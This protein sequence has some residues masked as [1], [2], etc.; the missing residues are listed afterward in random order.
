MFLCHNLNPF[1]IF[2]YSILCVSMCALVYVCQVCAGALGDQKRNGTPWHWIQT[3]TSHHGLECHEKQP[4]KC[5]LGLR[6]SSQSFLNQPWTY[7]CHSVLGGYELSAL[8]TK[9][10]GYQSTLRIWGRPCPLTANP[11]PRVNSSHK[12]KHIH[13][14]ITLVC[15]CL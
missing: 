7:F 4:I 11:Q 6:E 14:I 3:V 10:R 9:E 13:L 2:T 12:N 8:G 15:F 5:G 1:K